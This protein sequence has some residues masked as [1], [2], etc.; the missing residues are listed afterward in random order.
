[1]TDKIQE[2]EAD[3]EELQRFVLDSE[4]P[5]VEKILTEI[6]S[7]QKTE[8]DNLKVNKEPEVPVPKP[9]PVKV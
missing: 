8:L 6:I 9:V 4:R 5:R 3:I 1:M 2:L 7:K